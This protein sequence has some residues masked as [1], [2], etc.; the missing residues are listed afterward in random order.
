MTLPVIDCPGNNVSN[1]ATVVGAVNLDIVWVSDKGDFAKDD[2]PPLQMGA[3]TCSTPA[4]R[5][6]C[7]NSFVTHFNLKNVEGA[8]ATYAK[9][10]IYFLP[11]C[12]PHIP[13]GNTGGENFGILARIP[14]L[15]K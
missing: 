9:K 2:F 12:T 6:A 15:V 3:W 11:N 5:A 4:D 1:C 7:W 13:A 8:T 14:V 10:S